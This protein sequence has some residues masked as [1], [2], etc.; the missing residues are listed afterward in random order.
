MQVRDLA[1]AALGF[2]A[3]QG[4]EDVGHVCRGSGRRRC[5]CGG[6]K[7]EAQSVRACPHRREVWA[8]RC[9]STG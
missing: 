9:R 7:D 5:N 1:A 3:L 4:I 6:G 2:G 8:R